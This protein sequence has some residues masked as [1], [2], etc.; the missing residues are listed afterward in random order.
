M[1][2]DNGSQYSSNEYE[3]FSKE[4]GFI[5][6]TSSPYHAQA[7]GLAEKSVQ[8]IKHLLEKAKSDGKDPYISLLELCNAA[9]D[10]LGLPAQLL[11]NRH[12]KSILPTNPQ[13]L[14]PKVI[15][16]NMVTTKLKENQVTRKHY[17]NKGTKQ[18][19]DLLPNDPVRVQIQNRWIPAKVIKPADYPNS[20][21]IRCSNGTQLHQN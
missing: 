20:Y 12:L 5:H 3:R 4:W 17:Y 2:S 16:P 21:F 11:M 15:D 9:V 10:N 18:Q 8:T 14:S 7:N 19:P 13:Q 1:K 6:V